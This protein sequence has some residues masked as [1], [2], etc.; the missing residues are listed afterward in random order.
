[1]SAAGSGNTTASELELKVIPQLELKL[2][3]ASL[4]A[5]RSAR[6]AFR[7][8]R[9]AF[10]SARCAF[11]TRCAKRSARS[12]QD[13]QN[14][15]CISIWHNKKTTEL[16]ANATS[17]AHM[18]SSI[19]PPS[20]IAPSDAPALLCLPLALKAL[21]SLV[22]IQKP[23]GTPAR[24]AKVGPMGCTK[25]ERADPLPSAESAG[26]WSSSSEGS[27]TSSNDTAAG[28]EEVGRAQNRGD[29]RGGKRAG[30]NGGK[31]GG[32]NGGT[33]GASLQAVL[34]C[35]ECGETLRGGNIRVLSQRD[36]P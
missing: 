35:S 5:F 18:G 2:S 33:R 24:E 11:R 21:T 17:S 16:S 6:C 9:C 22:K 28:G 30:E 29:K 14:E 12:K 34:V 4:D 13:V 27:S 25:G 1:M 23:S 19:L 20:A 10:R 7:S 15:A 26:S 3:H 8:A 32:G 31:R 36:P